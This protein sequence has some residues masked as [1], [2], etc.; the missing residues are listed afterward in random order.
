MTEGQRRRLYGGLAGAGGG[1][2]GIGIFH[3]LYRDEGMTGAVLI[4]IGAALVAAVLT[5]SYR[6]RKNR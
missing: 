2:I 4:A 6:T 1:L 5:A 3:V